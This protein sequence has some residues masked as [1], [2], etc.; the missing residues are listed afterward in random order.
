VLANNPNLAIQIDLDWETYCHENLLPTTVREVLSVRGEQGDVTLE[1]VDRVQDFERH[2][3]RPQFFFSDVPEVL[4]VG[5]RIQN[6][7]LSVKGAGPY[8]PI[9]QRTGTCAMVWPVPTNDLRLSYS[10]RVQHADLSAA[11]DEWAG[12]PNNIIHLIEWK[13]VEFAYKTGIK[14]DSKRAMLAEREVE[15]RLARALA[16]HSAQPNRRRIP[17]YYGAPFGSNPRRRWASQTSSADWTGP[18]GNF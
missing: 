2:I 10:Y 9:A 15:R 4:Y 14:N 13:A 1:F 17:T 7:Q 16:Q 11:T 6:T 8:G 3:P 18:S 12:V 5:G